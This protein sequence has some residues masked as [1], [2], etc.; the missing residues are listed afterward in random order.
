MLNTQNEDEDV[1]LG[2]DAV[3]PHAN[4]VLSP[5]S[6]LATVYLSET[7]V[8]CC[9]LDIAFSFALTAAVC[10]IGAGQVG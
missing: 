8:I 3:C 2:C 4:V 10:E 6:G 7:L 5:S 1:L 9:K